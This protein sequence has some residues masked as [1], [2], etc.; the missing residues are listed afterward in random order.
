MASFR[1]AE[2]PLPP[3]IVSIESAPFDGQLAFVVIAANGERMR[4]SASGKSITPPDMSRAATH[5]RG[6]PPILMSTGDDYYFDRRSETARLPA[7]R[8]IGA[9]GVRYYLEPL[10]GDIMKTVDANGRWY[11]WLHEAPHRLDFSAAL[12][13]RPLWDVVMLTLMLGVTCVC[14]TGTWLGL[15]RLRQHHPISPPTLDSI[16]K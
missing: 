9:D 11:R 6:D 3:A 12:R 5:L 1:G 14:G 7:Y 15:R 2:S 16:D 13:K 10:S 4:I 8:V